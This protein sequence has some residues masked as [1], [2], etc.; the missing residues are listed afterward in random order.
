M[1]HIHVCHW[2]RHIVTYITPAEGVTLDRWGWYIVTQILVISWW[3][4]VAIHIIVTH[5]FVLLR[6][7]VM[8]LW[9]TFQPM[10]RK[11][12]VA[13]EVQEPAEEE[14]MGLTDEG[15]L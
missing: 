8:P 5:N 2:Q 10:Y 14:A 12:P 4:P 1:S 7:R 15:P 13:H 11:P 6:F 9:Q 3:I